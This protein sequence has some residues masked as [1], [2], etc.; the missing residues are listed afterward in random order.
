[1]DAQGVFVKELI[2]GVEEKATK[3]L[4]YPIPDVREHNVTLYLSLDALEMAAQ[5][6]DWSADY[7]GLIEEEQA[8]CNV[9]SG[10][11]ARHGQR[12]GAVTTK[13]AEADATLTADK[14]VEAACVTDKETGLR[15]PQPR[16]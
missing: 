8:R 10:N 14:Q 2:E 3:K 4:Q 5:N 15:I 12:G 16:R 13:E 11:G 9:F 6:L 1:M 7:G